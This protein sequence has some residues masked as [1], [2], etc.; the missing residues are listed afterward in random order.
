M[1]S[2]Q[3][4]AEA[5]DDVQSTIEQMCVLASRLGCEIHVVFNGVHLYAR[6]GS[7]P[8]ELASAWEVA[9]LSKQPERVASAQTV[10]LTRENS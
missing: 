7:D 5:G 1:L 6:P 2:I 10:K 4:E 9:R 3:V 8:R